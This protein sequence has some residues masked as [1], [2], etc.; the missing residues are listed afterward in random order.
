MLHIKSH[1]HKTILVECILPYLDQVSIFRLARTSKTLYDML[2]NHLPKDQV[3]GYFNWTFKHPHLETRWI[4]ARRR[5]ESNK[6]CI[7][8][9]GKKTR[10]KVPLKTALFQGLARTLKPPLPICETCIRARH[11][12]GTNCDDDI[13][14]LQT[15]KR[16]RTSITLRDLTD[17]FL[18]LLEQYEAEETRRSSRIFNAK[19]GDVLIPKY[20]GTEPER[21]TIVRI[22]P[23]NWGDRNYQDKRYI[24]DDGSWIESVNGY[25]WIGNSYRSE[26]PYM[27]HP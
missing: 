21:L 9:C 24:M 27:L 3:L 23:F 1:L 25:R 17:S 4:M 8:G 22:C 7:G 15:I 13:E 11:V 2:E 14:I 5:H 20:Q 19:V 10:N 18:P 16:L 26:V 6:W 12:W